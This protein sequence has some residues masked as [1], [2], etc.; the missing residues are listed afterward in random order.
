MDAEGAYSWSP[1]ILKSLPTDKAR[2]RLLRK[3]GILESQRE[4][5]AICRLMSLV[6]RFFKV[7]TVG[8]SFMEENRHV[9][10]Y[11]NGFSW[12][13]APRA[14][15]LCSFTYNDNS[16]LSLIIP[17]T[18]MDEKYRD[19]PLVRNEPFVRFYAGISLF[20][21][22]LKLGV[23][24]LFGPEPRFDLATKRNEEILVELA[25]SISELLKPRPR[26]GNFDDWRQDLTM[27]ESVL[28]SAKDPLAKVGEVAQ[29]I[30]LLMQE[31]HDVSVSDRLDRHQKRRVLQQ[32]KDSSFVLS[33]EV[34][35]LGSIMDDSIC[36][37]LCELQMIQSPLS[38]SSS[39]LSFDSNST[40]SYS[41]RSLPFLQPTASSTS[42]RL[43]AS[44]FSAGF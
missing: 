31:F 27:Q 12:K 32:L 38:S 39:N 18:L 35:R 17:D 20:C 9:F 19:C 26:I 29:V 11:Q 3:I 21:D 6:K 24:V 4:E 36:N 23:L 30:H 14:V 13:E 1:L 34:A 5:E 33:N 43:R 22:G 7:D 16:S 15:G 28:S 10:R 44:S 37:M 42:I 2:V 40:K 41:P 8:L 25:A